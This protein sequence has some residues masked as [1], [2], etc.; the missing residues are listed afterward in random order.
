MVWPDMQ[1][2][3]MVV[4]DIEGLWLVGLGFVSVWVKCLWYRVK[5]RRKWFVMVRKHED[6]R[7]FEDARSVGR[8][9]LYTESSRSSLVVYR[10]SVSSL[11]GR[12]NLIIWFLVMIQSVHSWVLTELTSKWWD[13][14]P[15]LQLP[16]YF[17]YHWQPNMSL[18][19]PTFQMPESKSLDS[20][21]RAN[22][23][24]KLDHLSSFLKH[25]SWCCEIISIVLLW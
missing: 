3:L 1:H 23:R 21:L 12:D 22:L 2:I 13:S 6:I 24:G 5:Y 15:W 17:C 18:G 20:V 14:L 8:V 19:M 11:L 16:D 9:E 4:S 25:L 7:L 10:Q